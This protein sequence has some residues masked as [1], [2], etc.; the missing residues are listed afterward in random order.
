MKLRQIIYENQVIQEI[1]R[2][3][4]SD[5]KKA[6]LR[7]IIINSYGEI[8]IDGNACLREGKQLKRL[9]WK[10]NRVEGTF[11]MQES[12]LES[13][14][15]FPSKT[16]NI[17]IDGCEHLYSLASDHDINSKSVFANQI[18]IK[19]LKGARLQVENF[20]YVR[21]CKNLESLEGNQGYIK[22]V[23]I[24]HCPNFIQDPM[25]LG[26]S[27]VMADDSCTK[28]PLIRGLLLSQNFG[29]PQNPKLIFHCINSPQLKR[30]CDK[31]YMKGPSQIVNLMREL[32]DAGFK[33]HARL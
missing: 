21:G 31:Y 19:N 32:R 15:N 28:L 33:D 29:T 20:L 18:P 23:D 25:T 17:Q 4:T 27:V 3:F 9:P 13:L 6:P 16:H 12:D 26:C 10:I 30:I 8:D 14:E 2:Y 1:E 11:D 22:D 7:S 24:T 5:G